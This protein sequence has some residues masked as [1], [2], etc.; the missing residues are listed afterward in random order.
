MLCMI[1][2]PR[3]YDFVGVF[4]KDAYDGSDPRDTLPGD[5]AAPR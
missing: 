3:Y 5:T 2:G 4:R 1:T